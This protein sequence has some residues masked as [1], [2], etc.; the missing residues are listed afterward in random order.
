MRDDT[1]LNIVPDA[2]GSIVCTCFHSSIE[3]L[4]WGPSSCVV[5][6]EKDAYRIPLRL[7]VEFRPAALNVL[8]GG[9]PLD[10]LLDKR[11]LLEQIDSVLHYNLTRI[12][13]NCL[14]LLGAFLPTPNV[15]FLLPVY[16]ALVLELDTLFMRYFSEGF[17]SDC[18]LVRYLVNSM[19]RSCGMLRVGDLARHLGYSER[20][21]HRV[22]K[23]RLGLSLKPLARTFRVNKVCACLDAKP[24]S[25]TS[26]AMDLGYHDQAHFIHEFKAVCGVTPGEYL[27]NTSDFYNESFKLMIS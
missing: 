23:E 1:P 19:A 5:A 8:L 7:F 2:S 15:Q 17:G 13:E 21:L 9:M 12:L 26:L 14:T 22:S 10:V 18:V 20:H 16:M 11:F 25:L 3:L 4:L 24:T 6:V 27:R